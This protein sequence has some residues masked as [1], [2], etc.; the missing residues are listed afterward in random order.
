MYSSPSY[1]QK[2]HSFPILNLVP[3]KSLGNY[4]LDTSLEAILKSSSKLLTL[5]YSE[6]PKR[7]N[8][9]KNH[10]TNINTNNKQNNKQNDPILNELETSE[11]F[12]IIIV[13]HPY[14]IY[15]YFEE[16]WQRLEI[17]RLDVGKSMGF[18][19]KTNLN[20][21]GSND[22]YD[23]EYAYKVVYH[24][25][26]LK[27][28]YSEVNKLMGPTHKG[29]YDKTKCEYTL[30][31]PGVAFV[32]EIPEQWSDDSAWPQGIPVEFPDKSSPQLKRIFIFKGRLLKNAISNL[33]HP[34][35][36]SEGLSNIPIQ[37]F[38]GKG[39]IAGKKL[40]KF[41]DYVQD[42]LNTLGSPDEI[43]YKKHDKL[44]IFSTDNSFG[45][46]NSGIDYFYNYFRFG[47]D[48]MFKGDSHKVEKIILHTNFCGSSDFNVYMR[49]NFFI[50]YKEFFKV[51]HVLP[52]S[53]KLLDIPTNTN[54]DL[55][56]LEF[57]DNFD[58]EKGITS[59]SHFD[60]IIKSLP[61]IHC[62]E[63][64]ENPSLLEENPFGGTKFHPFKFCIIE[65][66]KNNHINSIT[67]F[68]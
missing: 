59:L 43:F 51:N 19:G 54:G 61:N 22:S 11:K 3:H 17:I 24:N 41:G 18:E 8:S 55:E 45:E 32:F 36:P 6:H 37:V 14:H 40:I 1:S 9:S 62:G 23:E 39:I 27:P 60:D 10:N 52:P 28:S 53:T 38:L 20:V 44:K 21:N 35:P 7:L 42:V 48:I 34:N 56:E 65:T 5:Y 16:K 68:S 67:L 64:I 50:P 47:F 12:N 46:I 31:Y 29:K 63:P 25:E 26:D 49:C 13:K 2:S 33:L 66:M 30:E 57:Y 4:V 58:I 15:L